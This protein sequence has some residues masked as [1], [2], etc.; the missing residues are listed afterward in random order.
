MKTSLTLFTVPLSVLALAACGS[1]SHKSSTAASPPATSSTAST[2][3]TTTPTTA[4][5]AT[6]P[7]ISTRTIAQLGPVL[8]NAQGRT[9]YLFVPD[10]AKK[11][12]CVGGCAAVWFPAFLPAGQKPVAS[13]LVKQ[14]L[15]GSDPDPAGGNVITYAGWPLYTY[16]ADSAPGTATGQA[17][18]LN[19]GL[20][21]VLS[22]TGKTIKTK[23]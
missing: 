21:Y 1:S 6:G 18:T 16:V 11:V 8:V 23:P 2:P 20:W 13:G 3:A 22:P 14:S 7:K 15:L 5:A 17:I 12:T 4:P 19:G 9:L 10:N